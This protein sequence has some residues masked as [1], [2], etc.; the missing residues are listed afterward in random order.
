MAVSVVTY[1]QFTEWQDNLTGYID[2]KFDSERKYND[3]RFERID[4][5]LAD[6]DS[7][8]AQIDSKL[9]TLTNIVMSLAQTVQEQNKRFDRIEERLD[10]IES[11]LK[12]A[13]SMSSKHEVY[14]RALIK[15]VPQ[16]KFAANLQEVEDE[17]DS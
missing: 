17:L 7:H 4:S 14:M 16:A 15:T 11:D 13:L 8:F 1:D 12:V 6:H 3:Q 9:D 2:R 5:K 10:R